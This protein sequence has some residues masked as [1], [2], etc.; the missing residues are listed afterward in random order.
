VNSFSLR[1]MVAG[2]L[3]LALPCNSCRSSN[4]SVAPPASPQQGAQS[5]S[6]IKADI[7][8]QALRP[9]GP[10]SRLDISFDSC[11]AFENVSFSSGAVGYAS[12]K[13]CLWGTVDGGHHW[14]STHCFANPPDV[15]EHQQQ[16]AKFQFVTNND[17]WVI[18]DDLMHTLDGGHTWSRTNFSRMVVRG[19]RF[20]DSRVGYWVGEEV[21]HD[22][23]PGRGVIFHTT[24]GGHTWSET[25]VGITLDYGWRLR[26]VWTISPSE[27]WVVGDVLIHTVDAGKT[28]QRV[29]IDEQWRDLTIQFSSAS[30]GWIVRQPEVNY[31]LTIDGGRT[32]EPKLLPFSHVLA[33]GLTF[34]E[35]THAWAAVDDVFRTVDCGKTWEIY[36]IR[37]ASS[38]SSGPYYNIQYLTGEHLVIATG[39]CGIAIV[40]L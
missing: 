28:W 23:S 12:E 30:V 31:L 33:Q 9:Q 15:P 6:A 26:D 13:N 25:P 2:T 7:I 5:G 17:A 36:P 39:N 10:R 24:D 21:A 35:S 27:A 19:L 37:D 34:V 11:H 20:Y 1:R 18:A 29:V 32:W 38:V 40:D 22:S 4:R 3:L 8:P 16:I 14:T